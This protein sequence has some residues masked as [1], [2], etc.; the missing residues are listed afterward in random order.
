MDT[1]DSKFNM[2]K[3]NLC[4]RGIIK[5]LCKSGALLYLISSERYSMAML[6]FFQTTCSHDVWGNTAGWTHGS[7]VLS[8]GD[9]SRVA[10]QLWKGWLTK[11]ALTLFSHLLYA[12][13]SCYMVC[14]LTSLWY[15]PKSVLWFYFIYLF[16]F[17][18]FS[19]MNIFYFFFRIH[20][21]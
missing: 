15:S 16:I 14:F 7:S 2:T 3:L 9:E 4:C 19:N 5:L 6:Y 17:L 10:C 13:S 1:I 11:I 8:L 12:F 21:A 18:V 20:R